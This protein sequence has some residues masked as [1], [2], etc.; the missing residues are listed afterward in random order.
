ML[1]QSGSTVQILGYHPL[2]VLCLSYLEISAGKLCQNAQGAC[3]L[4]EEQNPG[5]NR[6]SVVTKILEVGRILHR[7]NLDF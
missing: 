7:F 3:D 2:E 1:R 6:I 5:S 4:S